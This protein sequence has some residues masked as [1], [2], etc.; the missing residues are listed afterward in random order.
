MPV[1]AQ[2]TIGVTATRRSAHRRRTSRAWLDG[3]GADVIGLNCSVGPQTIL[4][5][6]ERMVARHPPQAERAA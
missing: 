1:I 5:G 4:E 3:L 6:I 2:M